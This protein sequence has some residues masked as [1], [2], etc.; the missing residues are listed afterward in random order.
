MSDNSTVVIG[1]PHDG[2]R[3]PRRYADLPILRLPVYSPVAASIGRSG[4][5]PSFEPDIEI[6]EYVR[7]DFG[8][9][10]GRV[11]AWVHPSVRSPMRELLSG[12]R[13]PL[14]EVKP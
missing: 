7:Q 12:Y 4:M 8:D 6:E 3:I 10:T 5:T 9:S 2:Q 14:K 13:M 1:G 11:S